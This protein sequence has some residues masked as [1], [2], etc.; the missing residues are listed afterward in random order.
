MKK[1]KPSDDTS[2]STVNNYKAV[3]ILGVIVLIVIMFGAIMSQLNDL[4]LKNQ[5]EE[6]Y[7]KNIDKK[8]NVKEVYMD[9]DKSADADSPMRKH[10]VVTTMSGKVF[11][12]YMNSIKPNDSIVIK[13]NEGVFILCLESGNCGKVKY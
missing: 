2:P 12:V 5:G 8:F 6:Y 9:V 13:K 3:G 10:M 4:T 11:N 1:E 7:S